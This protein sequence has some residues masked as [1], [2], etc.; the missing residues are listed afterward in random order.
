MRYNLAPWGSYIK[1]NIPKTYDKQQT[2]NERAKIS[3]VYISI[4]FVNI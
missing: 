3:Q 1:K 4:Y 2:A